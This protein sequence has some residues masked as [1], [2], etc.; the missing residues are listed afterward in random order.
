MTAQPCISSSKMYF[1][2]Q[3]L[4]THSSSCPTHPSIQKHCARQS[5]KHH[6]LLYTQAITDWL[7]IRTKIQKS[8]MQCCCQI[9]PSQTG[10]TQQ[11]YKTKTLRIAGRR[12]KPSRPP[13]S[14]LCITIRVTKP[15]LDTRSSTRASCTALRR[16][17]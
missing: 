9:E 13:P 3:R 2:K 1:P 7:H 10:Y 14:W 12:I 4:G 11:Q 5:L 6:A 8:T 17:R 16:I 15:R